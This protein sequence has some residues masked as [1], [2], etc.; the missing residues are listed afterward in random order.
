[1]PKVDERGDNGNGGDDEDVND[2]DNGDCLDETLSRFSA[3]GFAL[4]AA[5]AGSVDSGDADG[6]EDGSGGKSDGADANSL[7]DISKETP[8]DGENAVA[9]ACFGEGCSVAC[10]AW[11]GSRGRVARDGRANAPRTYCESHAESMV[12]AT[13]AA[14]F[15]TVPAAAAAAEA[16]IPSVPEPAVAVPASLA[17]PVAVP[18]AKAA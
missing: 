10:F 5:S 4:A 13:A 2:D 14:V 8:A 17:A 6:D 3:T 1:M 11:P 7:E 12:P 15:M 18:P 9:V 16:A